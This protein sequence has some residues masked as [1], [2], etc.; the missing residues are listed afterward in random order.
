[1]FLL[2]GH[3][4]CRAIDER[5][6]TIMAKANGK[7]EPYFEIRG[8]LGD[9]AHAICAIAKSEVEAGRFI[10]QLL[11]EQQVLFLEILRFNTPNTTEADIR[12]SIGRWPGPSASDED[13]VALVP[14]ERTIH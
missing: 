14:L 7:H 11:E 8:Y 2:C 4:D 13:R 3:P 12:K 9:A 10:G 6:A 5:G 1:M